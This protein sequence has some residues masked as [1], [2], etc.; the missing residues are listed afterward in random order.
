MNRVCS[1]FEV[2]L[3]WVG[4]V[5]NEKGVERIYLPGLKKQELGERIREEFPDSVETDSFLTDARKELT[6]YFEGRRSKFGM[7]LD[8]SRATPFQ[9]AAYRIMSEIRFGEV[10]SYRWLAEKMGNRAAV[11]AAGSANARNRWPVVIPCH[12]IVASDG[13]LTG[14]SAPGGLELKAR[15]LALEGVPVRNGKVATQLD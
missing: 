7:A 6:E 12:R 14:F 13:R 15:L 5:G 1:M 2:N 4:L 3:G 8:L 10:H 9:R 11:R